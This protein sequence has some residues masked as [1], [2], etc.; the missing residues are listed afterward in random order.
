MLNGAKMGETKFR[1]KSTCEK[2]KET[3]SR[4]ILFFFFELF[5]IFLSKDFFIYSNKANLCGAKWCKPKKVYIFLA[6]D[7]I[8]HSNKANLCGAKWCKPKKVYIFLAKD[9]HMSKKS[10]NF[11][12]KIRR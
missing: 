9:L 11:A 4:K 7:F 1:E 3:E 10:S 8:I 12:P 5:F 2:L 6:K